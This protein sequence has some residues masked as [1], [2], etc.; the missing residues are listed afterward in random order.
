MS[1]LERFLTAQEHSYASALAEIR[2]GR[3]YSHWMW[4]I[5][6][7]IAGLGYSAM[8]QKYAISDLDEARDYLAHPVLGARLKEISRALT[9]L[10]SYDAQAVMGWPD[11]L[12]LRSCM[13]LFLLAAPEEAV[14]REVLEKFYGGE[15]DELTL[16]MLGDTA[17]KGR[18]I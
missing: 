9:E 16:R 7:Q 5:F 4:Y 15:R 18:E 6:P 12:K 1:S 2:A 10:E 17:P 13:T 8:A 14:F 11:C 3:K